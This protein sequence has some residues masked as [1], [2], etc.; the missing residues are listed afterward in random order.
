MTP[1]L[2]TEHLILRAFE[3]GDV[4][5]LLSLDSDPEVMR[6]LTDGKSS[7]YDTIR[8]VTLPRFLECNRQYPGFGYWAA[9]EK[10]RGEFIGWF[11]FRPFDEPVEIELGYRLVKAAWGKGYGTEGARAL[12]RKGFREQGVERVRAKTLAANRASRRVLEK[13]GLR[14]ESE[15]IEV[16]FPG[17]DQR[18]VWYALDRAGFEQDQS[19]H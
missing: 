5:N 6:Y 19:R 8:G 7:D 10:P 13:A 2:E 3:P 12:I 14:F 17:A 9:L 15:F 1:F 16:Q 4:D 11:H 18:A